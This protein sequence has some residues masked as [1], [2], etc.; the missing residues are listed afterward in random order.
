M[1]IFK[2]W[3]LELSLKEVTGLMSAIRGADEGCFKDTKKLVRHVRGLVLHNADTKT[4]F[5][6]E[7]AID[8]LYAVKTIHSVIT[9][10][11]K[12]KGSISTHWLDHILLAIRIIAKYHP[13]GKDWQN[14]LDTLVDFELIRKNNY[15]IIGIK[16]SE[17]IIDKVVPEAIGTIKKDTHTSNKNSAANITSCKKE[18]AESWSK[19]MELNKSMWLSNMNKVQ[20]DRIV[21]VLDVNTEIKNCTTEDKTLLKSVKNILRNLCLNSYKINQL[22]G[23]HRRLMKMDVSRQLMEGGMNE[24]MMVIGAIRDFHPDS[25]V[26]KALTTKDK[27]Y[28]YDMPFIN[29]DSWCKHQSSVMIHARFSFLNDLQKVNSEEAEFTTKIFELINTNTF[30]EERTDVVTII[31]SIINKIVQSDRFS[32]SIFDMLKFLLL[33][34]PSMFIKKTIINTLLSYKNNL[35]SEPYKLEILNRFTDEVL[36]DF[37]DK[38][39]LEIK[40]YFKERMSK[41]T[42]D[43]IINKNTSCLNHRQLGHADEWLD[44]KK[45]FYWNVVPTMDIPKPYFTYT[46]T[47]EGVLFPELEKKSVDIATSNIRD[48]VRETAEELTDYLNEWPKGALSG[49][50]ETTNETIDDVLFRT[51]DLHKHLASITVEPVSNTVSND[52]GLNMSLR[53]PNYDINVSDTLKQLKSIFPQSPEDVEC[54]L[55]ELN[56]Y[57]TELDNIKNNRNKE[58]ELNEWTKT[59]ARPEVLETMRNYSL[60][61]NDFSES[62]EDENNFIGFQEVV[63]SMIFDK[64]FNSTYTRRLGNNSF[65]INRNLFTLMHSLYNNNRECFDEIKQINDAVTIIREYIRY[66]K[67]VKSDE[68]EYWE[69]I[70]HNI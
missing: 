51:I 28:I 66:L 59:I 40:E 17:I 25:E 32:G 44:M 22:R 24:L 1:K 3:V 49:K 5:M 56:A 15:S 6:I 12:S 35:V 10:I 7:G 29:D 41:Y 42:H 55:H 21:N 61:L 60:M 16:R 2:D 34:H 9:T 68:A 65:I 31:E 58:P 62:I 4:G 20:Y 39:Y 57:R 14:I 46:P 37:K 53:V 27:T 36:I 64:N 67:E 48:S 8:G 52:D 63:Y 69:S 30:S 43:A 13:D 26:G 23:M 54:F 45:E 19:D 11:K 33:K 70:L 38:E 47:Q 50:K 18:S